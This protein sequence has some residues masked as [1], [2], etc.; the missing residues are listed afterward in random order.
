MRWAYAI[1]LANLCGC[2]NSQGY[3]LLFRLI[4]HARNL[5]SKP[6][7]S[8]PV[9]VGPEND[10]TDPDESSLPLFFS[11]KLSAFQIPLEHRYLIA[12]AS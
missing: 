10:R 3:L 2:Q 9:I 11:Y 1:H 7:P 8:G 5:S 4:W 12:S 6:H